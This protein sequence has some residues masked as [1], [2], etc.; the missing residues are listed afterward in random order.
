[1]TNTSR[2]RSSVATPFEDRITEVIGCLATKRGSAALERDERA[3]QVRPAAA[4][5]DIDLDNHCA[6]GQFAA[7]RLDRDRDILVLNFADE[8]KR[9]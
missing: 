9:L 3:T 4:T 7:C 8:G 5:G 2:A 6:V 1:M